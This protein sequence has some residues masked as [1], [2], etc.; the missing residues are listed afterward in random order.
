MNLR[1]AVEE[2]IESAMIDGWH[3]MEPGASLWQHNVQQ[4]TRAAITAMRE[5]LL[6]EQAVEALAELHIPA[7]EYKALDNRHLR[8]IYGMNTDAP[9]CKVDLRNHYRYAAN[10]TL[11]AA[12]A[13]IGA[14]DTDD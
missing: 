2:V 9:M 10:I 5:A 1:E 3:S 14:T 13:A 12:L 4:Q 8:G 6:S 11:S 7:E